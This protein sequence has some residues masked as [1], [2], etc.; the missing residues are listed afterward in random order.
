[1]TTSTVTDADVACYALRLGDDALIH[2]QRLCEWAAGAP[3][4]EEDVA[5]L[6]LALDLLGQAR[7]LLS[8]A[9]TREHG[10]RDEDALAFRR[11]EVEFTNAL[12]FEIENGDFGQTMARQLLA[13]A[14]QVELWQALSA[15][16]DADLAGIAG[17]AVKEA[18]YH[19]RHAHGWVVR[20]GDGT[21]ESHTRMQA[22]LE[23]LWPF[24]AELFERDA[25]SERLHSAGIAPDPATLRP[26]WDATI[27]VVLQEA[28]LTRP[29][30]SWAPGGGRRGQHTEAMGY[31]LAELQHLHRSHPGARW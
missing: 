21:A 16:A 18:R 30:T 17:R 14:W 31:L 10:D 28:T 27:G 23:A 22:G 24:T 15:S 11:D 2:S 25:L 5:L 7:A 9:G 13:A 8:L 6:N 29:T 20:L 1:M 19:L 26:G 4:L 3:Q 12:L